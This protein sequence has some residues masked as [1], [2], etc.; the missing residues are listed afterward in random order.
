MHKN[1]GFHQSPIQ[2]A[3]QI[4]QTLDH[5]RHLRHN[6]RNL[7]ALRAKPIGHSL[8]LLPNRVT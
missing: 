7:S 3:M 8:H 4:E 2:A 6:L 1:L 5:S